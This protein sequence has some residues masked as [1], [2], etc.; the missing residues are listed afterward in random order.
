M[1]YQI[2]TFTLALAL[3]ISGLVYAQDDDDKK[4]ACEAIL[5]L[6]SGTR[7]PEC[8]PSLSRYFSIS[9][10]KW[11]D[12]ARA[13]QNF[14]NLCPIVSQDSAMA[15]RN[16]AIANGAGRCEAAS[17]NATLLTGDENTNYISNVLPDYCASYI[18]NGYSDINDKTPVYLGEPMRGG[19]WVEQGH[20][21][22]E[23]K[24]YEAR[25]NA[26][27]VQ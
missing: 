15:T 17:L 10:R 25:M 24:A 21:A 6:S 3:S 18:N 12:T 20:L 22:V 8:A 26:R 13:R 4:A 14:L 9:F 5:C 1:N 23:Q 7:P 27:Q 11:Y 16:S 19:Y 2:H